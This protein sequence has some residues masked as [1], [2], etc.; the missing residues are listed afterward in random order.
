M[1]PV[2]WFA[3]QS[4]REFEIGA[5]IR[6]VIAEGYGRVLDVARDVL[7]RP[8]VQAASDQLDMECR[9]TAD[10]LIRVAAEDGDSRALASFLRAMLL[11]R[12][13]VGGDGR[14]P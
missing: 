10:A 8:H 6:P 14:E 3:L 11:E 13:A 4:D 9:V 2:Q 7:A 5:T 1:R 12:A